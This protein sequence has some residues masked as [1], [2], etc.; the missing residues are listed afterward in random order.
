MGDIAPMDGVPDR[1]GVPPCGQ[2][3][4]WTPNGPPAAS[5]APGGPLSA[6]RPRSSASANLSPVVGSAFPTS[7][8]GP[9]LTEVEARVA[10]AIAN[11]LSNREA[12][13]R[14]LLSVKTIEFQLGDIFRKLGVR[15][16]TELA[17]RRAHSG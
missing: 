8:G 5:S 17:A 2:G 13:Q 4:P 3:E 6:S 11:G 14:L 15:N 12:A 7:S 10:T 16:R 9:A 1:G